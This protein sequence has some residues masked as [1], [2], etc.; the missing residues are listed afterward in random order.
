[1]KDYI[2]LITKNGIITGVCVYVLLYKFSFESIVWFLAGAFCGFLGFL[3]GLNLIA[4]LLQLLFLDRCPEELI[5]LSFEY[6]L[7]GLNES[8]DNY[9]YE[10]IKLTTPERMKFD[11]YMRE[12]EYQKSK[13]NDD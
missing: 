7:D 10:N 8:T 3:S 5:S 12:Y 4:L 1:M 9:K 6:F 2:K 13:H 11:S